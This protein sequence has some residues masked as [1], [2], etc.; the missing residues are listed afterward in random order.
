MGEDADADQVVS[1]ISSRAPQTELEGRLR[2]REP[3]QPR[4]FFSP[5]PQVMSP[6]IHGQL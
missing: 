3:L 6:I 1:P 4:P 2:D 5:A